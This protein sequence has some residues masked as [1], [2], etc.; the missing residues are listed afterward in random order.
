MDP[1]DTYASNCNKS[2]GGKT[3]GLIL[4]EERGLRKYYQ[5]GGNWE[6]YKEEGS[7][8]GWLGNPKKAN[9][10]HTCLGNVHCL[11]KA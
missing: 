11:E 2:K 6:C 10:K 9:E 8:K 7:L 5:F 3:I 1:E 4:W